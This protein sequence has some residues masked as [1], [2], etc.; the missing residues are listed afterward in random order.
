MAPAP[1]QA[2]DAQIS[3]AQRSRMDD[4]VKLAR[5]G[6]VAG[7]L[8][9]Y[10]ELLAATDAD[11]LHLNR[12]RV[13]QK[14]GRCWDARAALDRAGQSPR[15]PTVDRAALEKRIERYGKELEN[16]CRGRV[17]VTCELPETFILHDG[18]ELPCDGTSLEFDAG[19]HTIEGEIFGQRVEANVTVRGTRTSKVTL[20]PDPKQRLGIGRALL[21]LNQAQRA[22]RLLEKVLRDEES[23]EVYLYIA[24]TLIQLDRCQAAAAALE[25]APTAPPSAAISRVEFE[26]RLSDLQ[27]AFHADCGERVLLKCTPAALNL[28]IDGGSRIVCSPAPIYMSIGDHT[29]EAEPAEASEGVRPNLRRAFTVEAGRANLVELN[30]G[31]P[32]TI[33]GTTLWGI[34]SLA[35]GVAVVGGAIALDV[36][37]IG[38]DLDDYNERNREFANSASL[39]S[40]ADRLDNLQTLDISL[41][42][43]GGALIATGS[44]LLLYELLGW[45]DD[46]GGGDETAWAPTLTPLESGGFVGIGGRF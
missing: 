45:G 16:D 36:A 19:K 2:Q 13:L 24:E 29:V 14:L 39:Q 44:A 32:E 22:R 1:A 12:G 21:N 33:S 7:A 18:A 8:E 4:A 28:R 25:D 20:A 17:V 9:V 41:F 42:V 31:S 34:G 35:V 6:N 11:I 38:P 15:D 30:L 23:Q 46:D 27:D 43:V 40:A 26:S 10:D 3:R 37:V 5:D